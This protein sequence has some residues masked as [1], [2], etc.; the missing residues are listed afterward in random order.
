MTYSKDN[1]EGVE[2]DY[3]GKHYKVAAVEGTKLRM[4]SNLTGWTEYTTDMQLLLHNLNSGM[5]TNIVK[6]NK[7]PQIIN[8]YDIF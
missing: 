4:E 3:A 5:F 7:N 1:V 6:V 8:S 2:F